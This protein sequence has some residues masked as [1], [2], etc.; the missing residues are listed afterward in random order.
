[1]GHPLDFG[2]RRVKLDSNGSV[3]WRWQVIEFSG[4]S[5]PDVKLPPSVRDQIESQVFVSRIESSQI[6]LISRLE[7]FRWIISTE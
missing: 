1:M 6:S 2:C 3:E 5:Q 7:V 4:M